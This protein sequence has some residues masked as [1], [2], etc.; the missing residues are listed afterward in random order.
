MLDSPAPMKSLLSS[1]K[2]ITGIIP[3]MLTPFTAHNEVDYAGLDRLTDWYLASGADALF[4]VCQSSEMQFLSLAEKVAIAR[5]VVDRVAGR[6]P[7]LASGHTG[8]SH[9]EQRDELVAVA[10]TGVDVLVLVTNRLDPDRLGEKVYRDRF[11]RLVDA[12][13]GSLPLG[14]YECPAPYRRLLS[15][16]ELTM[17]ARSGRFVALKDVSCDLGIVTRRAALTAATPLAIINANA[18]IA[19]DAMRNG[20]SP[21]FC[22]VFT[23]FHPDLY[24]WLYRHREDDEEL[25]TDLAAFLALAAMAEGMGYPA[26]AKRFHQRLGTF[27]SAHSRAVT[28]DIAER[29]W[30]LDPILD[31]IQSTAERFRQRIRALPA[32]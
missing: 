30:A 7:V 29:F 2:T 15:D 4:A 21:G 19:Y 27:A 23:N 24:A 17:A 10:G 3:V 14:L 31:I 6:V 9:E 18:A 22:G 5:H 25:A 11:A 32:K 26:L 1:R 20:S 16:A 8:G 28:Y 12:L 13:P